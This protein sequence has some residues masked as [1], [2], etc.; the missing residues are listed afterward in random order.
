MRLEDR[1]AVVTGGASGIGRGIAIAFAEEGA[2]VA[3]GDLRRE[4]LLEDAG[5]PT[6]DVLHEM[7]AG[8]VHV[9]MDVAEAEGAEA[10][11]DAAVD[12]FGG[13]DILV[14]NAAYFPKGT[15]ET[16]SEEDWDRTFDVN[17]KGIFHTCRAALPHLRE[18]DQPRII[19]LGSQ[20]GMEGTRKDTPSYSASK[21]AV[22]SL[23]RQLAVEYADE[24][25]TVNAICP[26][27][28]RTSSTIPKIEDPVKGPILRE[29]T[30]LP[31]FGEPYD[32]GRTAVYL[33]T[34]DARYMTGHALVIDGGYIAT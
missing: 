24:A 3:I 16:L 5:D 18:S 29:N 33:A 15:I 2:N 32:I 13:V 4:P 9:E 26:G 34:E 21:G 25:I 27:I 30:L 19:N 14:N 6:V 31:Y 22:I 7:G 28:V 1:T 12:E 8:A 17:V 23:T 10:L 20:L 11:V